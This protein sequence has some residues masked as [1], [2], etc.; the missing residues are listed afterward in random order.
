MQALGYSLN[1]MTLFG[2]V[3]AIGLVVDDAIVVVER[4]LYLMESE[5]LSPKEATIKAMEQV[6]SAI[7]ATTLVL[8]CH[9]CPCRFSW[10]HYRKKFINN[11]QLPFQ[12]QCLSHH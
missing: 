8:L 5:K 4:V 6:S 7:I 2:L 9:L 12:P 1:M 3:L 10:R 11:S